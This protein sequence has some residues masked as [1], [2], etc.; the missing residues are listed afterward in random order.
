MKQ[1]LITGGSGFFGGILKRR[2]LSEG[3]NCVNI[4]LIPDTDKFLNL[5]SIQCDIRSMNALKDVF[6]ARRFDV[7]FHIAAMLA[8]ENI[9]KGSLWGSN[10]DGTRNIAEMAVKHGV[11]SMVFTSSNC[12]WG[13]GLGRPILEDDP[14][15]PVEIY[16]KSKLEGERILQKYTGKLNCVTIRCPTI[17]DEGRLGLL[18]I[19]F[20][21]IDE[22]RKVWVIDGG[23]N[24][25]QW[26]YAPDLADAC[27]R[28][29]HLERSTVF[30]IGSDN[31]KSLRD[32]YSYVIDKAGTGAR[33]VSIPRIPTIPLMKLAYWLK[34]SPLGPYQYRMI[35]EDFIFNTS[36]IKK[37]LG[38]QPTVTNEEMLYRS[39][40]YFHQNR[41]VLEARQNVSAHS[42]PADMGIIR[43]LKWLS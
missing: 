12:L 2:L 4:D 34:L 39:F 5:E 31:V 3:W 10:V 8:H 43:F 23:K 20:E 41:K 32:V 17:I 19:L 22:G 40:V 9:S 29:A 28:A 35:A 37:E 11:R 25:Y 38:W 15:H 33:L 16:G 21:F 42:K 26:I 6:S 18:S 7:V 14:P 1:A 36:R 27:I 13:N 30:N 24:I